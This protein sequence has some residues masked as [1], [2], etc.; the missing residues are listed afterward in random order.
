[1]VARARQRLAVCVA[2]VLAALAIAGPTGG[3]T[4]S[5]RGAWTSAAVKA[6]GATLVVRGSLG[7][8]AVDRLEGPSLVT[9]SGFWPVANGTTVG[10][11]ILR[12]V[13]GQQEVFPIVY[14]VDVRDWCRFPGEDG[15]GERLTIAW[16]GVS[17]ATR[18]NG[19]ILQ[20]TRSTLENP[21]P[22]A[23]VESLDYISAMTDSAPFL[24]AV[25]VE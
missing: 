5:M 10:R 7:Q 19:G 23:E 16:Q 18:L 11:Y 2:L 4:L 6:T 15:R 12:F 13:D 17:P 22:E 21:R 3:Q 25:T 24:I 20:L 14:G 1:M 8:P 9:R